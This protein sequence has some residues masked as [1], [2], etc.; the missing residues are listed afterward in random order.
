MR[1][2]RLRRI[3][4]YRVFRDCTWPTDL[5]EFG[6]FNAIYGWNGAG[7]TTLAALLRHLQ[8]RTSPAEGTVEFEFDGRTRVSG[9]DLPTATNLPAVRVFDRS[10]VENAL[11]R[12][13]SGMNNIYY[14]GQ[15]SAEK[16]GEAARLRAELETAR[17]EAADKAR[18]SREAEANIDRFCIEAAKKIKE[19][20]LGSASHATY[21][22]A[23]F[24]Q[25]VERLDEESAR[26][27]LLSDEQ[28][29]EL[30][31]QR[32]ALPKPS[33]EAVTAPTFDIQALAQ[34]TEAILI[35]SV[36]SQVIAELAA[37]PIVAHWVQLGLQLHDGEHDR[38]RCLFCTQPLTET[39]WSKLEAHFNDEF[40]RFQRR[41]G[42]LQVELGRARNSCENA[43]FPDSARFYDHLTAKAHEAI[44]A[45]RVL[46]GH[47]SR[48]LD[49]LLEVVKEKAANPFQPQV[50][51]NLHEADAPTKQCLDDAFQVVN[52]V[53]G[54]HESTTRD[55]EA[56]ITEACNALET[57]AVAEAYSEFVRLK[58]E[59]VR[60][61]GEARTAAGVPTDLERR[62]QELEREIVEH[63]RPAEELN[64]E[65][66]AY[67]GRDE[68][69]FEVHESGYVLV[70]AGAPVKNL[71]EGERTTIGFLYFLKSLQDKDF[72]VSSG[73]VVIDDPVSSLDANGLFSAFAYMKERTKNCGQ[74]FILTHNFPFFRQVRNWFHHMPGQKKADMSKHPA[75]F[76]LVK[77]EV[78]EATGVRRGSVGPIDPLLEQYESEYHYLFKLVYV[79]AKK[80]GPGESLEDYYGMPNIAR[81]LLESFLAF[82]Y[83]GRAHELHDVLQNVP[84]DAD[85]KTRILRFLHTYS[86]A[87]QIAE[88]EHDPHL[89]SA[90]PQVLG[91]VLDLIKQEDPTHFA[92]M[93]DLVSPTKPE[94]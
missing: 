48:R 19:L 5:H 37:D 63:R 71:S 23:R 4:N 32:R 9:S 77:T 10:F 45:V 79:V 12:S 50:L 94:E 34:R 17:K 47:G 91:D 90:T 81:R 40:T 2:S 13:Q 55:F 22:K 29:S 54:E 30:Q 49:V 80:V 86:H 62:I 57:C 69:Q 72:D 51:P 25:A 26:A 87:D 28:K 42:D 16:Q 89:L 75:R 35:E 65:L 43:N 74:L 60:L 6:Q 18:G 67:L 68:L 56:L 38:S 46:L 88:P 39:R 73:I 21:N 15:D 59:E 84:F 83:P 52:A 27:G 41:L 44:S 53:I 7:K 66:R 92:S 93:S 14:V 24:K 36:V 64:A 8:T 20:L 1:L 3:N 31:R 33:I 70:R 58:A 85:R 11:A 82:R 61:A 78:D 76:F